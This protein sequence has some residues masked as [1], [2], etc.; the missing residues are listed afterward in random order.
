VGSS[1]RRRLSVM[2]DVAKVTGVS[3][4]A[5]SRVLN[6]HLDVSAEARTR[7]LRAIDQL[8]YR[9]DLVARALVTRNSRRPGVVSFDTT[10]YGIERDSRDAGHRIGIVSLRTIDRA[11]VL[12]AIDYPTEQGVNGIVVVAPQRL[13]AEALGGM[14][15][16]MP[17]PGSG[18]PR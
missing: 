15:T 18:R 7:V 11:E 13:A 12:D 4:Q 16:G 17:V 5:V 2:A 8:G 1:P 9:R 14:P 10:P 6:D 3:H